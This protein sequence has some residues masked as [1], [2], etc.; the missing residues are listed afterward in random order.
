MNPVIR[1]CRGDP[2]RR[3]PARAVGMRGDQ[4]PHGEIRAI[5]ACDAPEGLGPVSQGRGPGTAAAKPTGMATNSRLAHECG[6]G[7][8]PDPSSG[9]AVSADTRP[10]RMEGLRQ[11][12]HRNSP[13]LIAIEAVVARVLRQPSPGTWPSAPVASTGHWPCSLATGHRLLTSVAGEGD[14]GHSS[15]RRQ[16]L[17]PGT[18]AV[19][20][21][22]AL[23]A[24][25]AGVEGADR[26]WGR[27]LETCSSSAG[28]SGSAA[29]RLI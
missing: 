20:G 3:R 15:R 24:E 7:C 6:D 10:G 23:P 17:R 8:D 1:C 18:A 12:G 25:A 22:H 11:Q 4:I 19:V 26:R 29:L 9:R 16:A 14:A 27:D 5:R 2:V 21:Y 13:S 28:S